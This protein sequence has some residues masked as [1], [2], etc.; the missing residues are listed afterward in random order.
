MTNSFIL[1]QLNFDIIFIIYSYFMVYISFSLQKS[2][3]KYKPH[4]NLSV[5]SFSSLFFLATPQHVDQGSKPGPGI[6][7]TPQQWPKPQQ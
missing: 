4:G 5:M 1:L 7:T 3:V 2:L 6:E